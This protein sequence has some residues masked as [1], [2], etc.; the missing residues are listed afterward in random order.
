[1]SK[2]EEPELLLAHYL[3]FDEYEMPDDPKNPG[4]E[5]VYFLVKVAKLIPR[6]P[7]KLADVESGLIATYTL[8]AVQTANVKYAKALMWQRQKK[9]SV[10][11]T[12]GRLMSELTSGEGKLPATI[13]EK[14]AKGKPTYEASSQLLGMA[15][16]YVDFYKNMLDNF[17]ATH[18]WAREKESQ[19]REENKI[20]G[21]E[22]HGLKKGG[23]KIEAVGDVDFG[24]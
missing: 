7:D 18:Y 8:A 9:V 22:P 14:I 1:M 11:S 6:T 16:A 2:S 10:D 13:A 23:G 17:K 4:F 24:N 12:L 15:D 5:D 21:Y 20:T 3:K 19:D